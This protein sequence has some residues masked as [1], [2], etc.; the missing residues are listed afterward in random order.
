[1]HGPESNLSY[2][3]PFQFSSIIFRQL[4]PKEFPST[5]L[6]SKIKMHLYRF[7]AA[8]AITFA[9]ASA[10]SLPQGTKPRDG[11]DLFDKTKATKCL[12]EFDPCTTKGPEQ[13]CKPLHCQFRGVT[14]ASRCNGP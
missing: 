4:Q 10:L 2:R 8:A 5:K 13:C 3:R 11:D 6:R 12:A 7:L 9:T 1:M 14:Q